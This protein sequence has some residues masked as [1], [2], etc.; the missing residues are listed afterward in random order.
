MLLMALLDSPDN[1][2]QAVEVVVAAAAAAAATKTATAAATD[3]IFVVR[4][5]VF[6]LAGSR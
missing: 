5:V 4:C 2:C 1:C 6:D 3:T